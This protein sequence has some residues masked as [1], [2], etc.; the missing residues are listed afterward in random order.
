MSESVAQSMEDVAKTLN[1]PIRDPKDYSH[2]R[3]VS[4]KPEKLVE[5]VR[6]LKADYGAYFLSTIPAYEAEDGFHLIYP[7]SIDVGKAMEGGWG[8]LVLDVMVGKNDPVV[9]SLVSEIPGAILYEREVFDMLGVR[10]NGLPDH[11]R[12]LTP[13]F[14]PPDLFPLRKENDAREMWERIGEEAEKT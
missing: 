9:D 12:L 3:Y 4:V 10:F 7:F 2:E 5:T 14:M 1:L 6:K 8:K 13:D 11:R